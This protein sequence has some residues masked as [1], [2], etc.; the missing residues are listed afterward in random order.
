MHTVLKYLGTVAA[1]VLT[2]Y[3]VPGV[4]VMGGWVTI[5]L[6]ALVWSVI[7]MVIKPVLAILTLPVTIIT[8]GLFSFVLNALLFWGM[9]LIVPGFSVAGF[10]PALLGALVLSILSWL[11][12]KVL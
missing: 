2:V 7:S 10:W 11:I 8:F 6:A 9:T 12:H 5:L 3:I 1:V 4:S